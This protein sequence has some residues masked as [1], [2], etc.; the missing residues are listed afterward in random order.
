MVVSD[1]A[2]RKAIACYYGHWAYTSSASF[3][4]G[5]TCVIE[6]RAGL[7]RMGLRSR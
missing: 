1:G 5:C 7:Y 4:G 3:R 6:I 2:G